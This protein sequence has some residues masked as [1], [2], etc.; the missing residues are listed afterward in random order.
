MTI[1]LPGLPPLT[2]THGEGRH[3]GEG[4][5]LVLT[6]DA[7]VDWSND[8]TGAPASHTSTSLSFE[9]DE[10]FQL[11][12]L[13]SVD[14]PRTTFDAA[15]L[16]LWVDEDCWAK[17]CFEYSPHGEEMVVSVVTDRFSDDANGPVVLEGSVWL[18]VSSLPAGAYAFHYSVNGTTWHF[19]RQFRL[20]TSTSPRVGFMSQAP[21]GP[22]A[23]SR[24]SQISLV[25]EQLADVRDGS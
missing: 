23:T 4:D 25:R 1:E 21:M 20:S 2:W 14:S 8:A 13:V 12:A 19:V 11:S 18:R 5:A 7:E 22:A 17:L 16:T 10:P 6:S 9:I 15:A 3:H 24:F